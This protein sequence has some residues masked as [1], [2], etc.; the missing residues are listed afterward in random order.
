MVKI[1]TVNLFLRGL[2][3]LGIIVAFGYWGYQAG[4]SP[5]V[6]VGLA[7]A[8][9]MLM[10]GF[11]SVVDFH[12]AGRLAEPLRLIQEL[13]ISGLAALALFASGRPTF[14]WAL[15]LVSILHHALVY[16]LGHRLIK[17]Q[18]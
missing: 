8:A 2:M 7:I 15:A 17:P 14:G 13:V 10:F 12:Q 4:S 1:D 6:R 9:P 5:V 11:W 18:T 3:E 16:L